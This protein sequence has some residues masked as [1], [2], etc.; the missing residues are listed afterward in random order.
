[1]FNLP[2]STP[3]A[4]EEAPA[5][6]E[7][8]AYL[9]GMAW[10]NSLSQKEKDARFPPTPKARFE[11][12]TPEKQASYNDDAEKAPQFAAHAPFT[13]PTANGEST[14]QQPQA[15][16]NQP[17]DNIFGNT[18]TPVNPPQSAQSTS[19]IFG[20]LD[21]QSQTQQ[22]QQP[23]SSIFGQSVG[24]PQQPT[25]NVFGQNMTHSQQSMSNLFGQN[26]TQPQQ[27][28]T[29]VFG[30]EV[31]HSQQ[32]N[33]SITGNDD[34]MSTSPDNSP[35]NSA[36]KKSGPFAFLNTPATPSQGSSLFERITKPPGASTLPTEE[37]QNSSQ[38][39]SQEKPKATHPL[40]GG[41]FDRIS[42]PPGTSEISSGNGQGPTQ[43]VANS[44]SAS[45]PYELLKNKPVYSK[46]PSSP[47]KSPPRPRP[48]AT[49]FTESHRKVA[50]PT[51][52]LPASQDG[53][54][55][56]NNPFTSIKFPPNLKPTS[57]PI[58]SPGK[59]LVSM[60]GDKDLPLSASNRVVGM[61][62][63]APPEFTDEQ[64]RELVTGYRLK[65]L[66]VG[67]RK[68]LM[69]SHASHTEL[70]A[71]YRFYQE[72]KQS[73][74]NA[75]GLT[76]ESIAGNKRKP[77]NETQLEGSHD[78][79]AK[80]DTPL[81]QISMPQAQVVTGSALN[82]NMP[83]DSLNK[84][85]SSSKRKADED[86]NNDVGKGSTDSAKRARGDRQISNPSLP[87]SSSN[88]QTSSIFKSILD[89]KEEA[90]TSDTSKPSVN[91]LK[92]PNPSDPNGSSAMAGN[93]FQF[94]PSS[95]SN[96][97]NPF[98]TS[99]S[100]SKIAPTASVLP[101]S[102]P[103]A[104]SPSK[105][106]FAP[107]ALPSS[108]ANASLFS[109]KPG[110]TKP[111]LEAPLTSMIQTSSTI[112]TNNLFS[113]KS[114]TSE[115]TPSAVVKPPSFKPPTFTTG[116]SSN[117]L[118]QFGKTAEETAKKEKEKRKAE[119]FDSDEDDEAEWER[120]DAEEQR[121]KKQKLEEA[122]MP[123][124]AK[125]IPGKG[126]V[127]GDDETDNQTEESPQSNKV[128][129]S[130]STALPSKNYGASLFAKQSTTQG[131][132]N[133]PNIFGHLSDVDSAAEGSKTGDADDE[134][135]SEVSDHDEEEND[136][137]KIKD[138]R[139]A[140]TPQDDA[141]TSETAPAFTPSNSFV[142]SNDP[143]LQGRAKPASEGQYP[144][145]SLFDRI[146]KDESGNAI[147]ESLPAEQN[148]VQNAPK[149]SLFPTST[150]NFFSQSASSSSGSTTSPGLSSS[151]KPAS[152]IFGQASSSKPATNIFGSATQ[153]NLTSNFF[154]QQ[155][156]STP[157]NKD[158]DSGS[159]SPGDHTWKPDTPIKFG[160][161][162]NAPGVQVTSPS[163][164]KSSFG[165]L[166]GSPPANTAKETPAK[167]TSGIFSTT[168]AKSP[169]VGFGFAFGGPPKTATSTLAPFSTAA[170]NTTSRATS[171]GASTAG[172]SATES[173]AEGG[174][175]LVEHHEQI[176]LT[177]GGPGEEDEDIVFE[178]RAKAQSYDFGQK[179]WVS[180]GLGIL[181]VL[182]HRETSK[183]RML[184][185]QE[186]I[187][188]II[189][190]AALLSAMK[191]EYASP[192]S[193]KMAVASDNGKLVTWFIRVGQDDDAH[194][195]ASVL[196]ENK[197]N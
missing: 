187:G 157:A 166:F 149:P 121:A 169:S 147:R 68:R 100:P 89:G 185:R 170:S 96:S 123:K 19:N 44:A 43:G 94:K 104:D 93:S 13:W 127:L 80:L 61:P 50:T 55:A 151:S 74:I 86:I 190:N 23:I 110:S 159:P 107:V 69:K 12:L 103:A 161:S 92:D 183:T 3:K 47:T 188:K 195:L 49:S 37:R 18:A 174:N 5:Q 133:S 6:T 163:P 124:R 160:A 145:R 191:Y 143:R 105:S 125:F 20:Q 155:S 31:T 120:K 99:S 28:I 63:P 40:G 85:S 139:R 29:N 184:M 60:S 57:E 71:I 176:D 58:S 76:L 140:S 22:P 90:P 118:S 165:G 144:A 128:N 9:A 64:K 77:E 87:T 73:I 4:S 108:P 180:K 27:S 102:K 162:S 33:T 83:S 112:D 106:I 15:P 194:K 131:L 98:V 115:T 34:S 150:S 153:S 111:P 66:D 117:F 54:A 119:D 113:S 21:S 173:T 167:P 56:I 182:K 30:P 196:E 8:D 132:I 52:S 38:T 39:P 2:P 136:Q 137:S 101:P 178:A 78:K 32:P 7:Q 186:S 16:N 65:A 10:Y 51:F 130:S 122:L 116:G 142:A 70:E 82:P 95:T 109:I 138:G 11:S 62:P 26:S 42:K 168:P 88:S 67:L 53:K 114:S 75:G 25:S 46:P 59:A 192:K 135:E 193:V 45:D 154:G 141:K 148:E 35:Q 84:R 36:E 134:D 152:N 129:S 146:S 79:R 189:L 158:V 171:P 81:S 72:K 164:S 126:F 172:E 97:S 48:D 197:S 1:M 14:D 17:T 177:S 91:G 181:R 156:S 41:L 24:Q 175:E 179:I